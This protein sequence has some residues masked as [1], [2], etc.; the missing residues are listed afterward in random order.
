MPRRRAPAWSLIAALASV[1]APAMAQSNV[2]A[3]VPMASRPVVQPVPA[4]DS[5]SLNEALSR[6]ARDP[7][8]AAALVDAGNAALAMGDV[9]AAIGFFNRADQV[10][11]GNPSVKAGLAGALV[12]NENPFDAI[13]LFEQAEKAG[14][15]DSA[16]AAD[17][18]LAYDLVGDNLTAQRYYRLALTRAQNDDVTRRLVLSFAMAGDRRSAETTL[19][20]LLQRQDKAAWRTRAFA[21]AILGQTEEAV[22]I[23]NQTLPR[24]LAGAIAPYLR[25]MPRLTPA[26][27]AAA[28]NFG[29]FPRASEIGRDDPRVVQFAPKTR[30][31]LA[32]ADAALSPRGEPLGRSRTSR[33]SRSAAADASPAIARKPAAVAVNAAATRAAPPVPVPTR[34][35]SE[36][37]SVV[38]RGTS[39]VAAPTPALAPTLAPTAAAPSVSTPTPVGVQRSVALSVSGELPPVIVPVEAPATTKPVVQAPAP[40]DA[41]AA[42][43]AATPAAVPVVSSAA[44]SAAPAAAVAAVTPAAPPPPPPSPPPAR[45][46]LTDAFADFGRPT[47]D[48]APASGAVDLRRIAPARPKPKEEAKPAPPSHPSRIWV[49]VATG[50]DKKALAFDW[51]RMTQKADATLRG[52]SP[53]VSAWGQTNRLLTGPFPSEA[54]AN[55][56][57]A[58]LRKVD[59]DGAFVWNSPAGQVVD[60]LPT[61]K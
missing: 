15:I 61:G 10:S 44:P 21:L 56:F 11:P 13:P 25:Y 12:R 57:I 45:R 38:T 60:A 47:I 54:A 48:T 49:Q 26:Q 7:R 4:R 9:D 18:G 33:S 24:E 37:P 51:K 31:R 55:S 36:A 14:A 28:A 19:A 50:R 20:P 42:A 16:L 32:S 5:M 52:K 30:P 23:A 58:Q 53:N 17:R 6:L 59:I 41:A 39:L 29:H 27:Q 22:A 34:A 8:D 3:A 43:P 46:S 2:Q 35:I 40:M 1:S